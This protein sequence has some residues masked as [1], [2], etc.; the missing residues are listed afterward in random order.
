MR[1][2]QHR[3]PHFTR[4]R[5][6]LR[7]KGQVRPL[8][9]RADTLTDTLSDGYP[10][11]LAALAPTYAPTYGGIRRGAFPGMAY[12]IPPT[13]HRSLH[14]LTRPGVLPAQLPPVQSA[15]LPTG[16]GDRDGV[17]VARACDE[18]DIGDAGDPENA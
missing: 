13:L 14:G 18:S 2:T 4:M 12:G 7:T 9:A 16:K 8:T 17:A 10:E 3:A 15:Q 11:W 5:A 6:E 1:R